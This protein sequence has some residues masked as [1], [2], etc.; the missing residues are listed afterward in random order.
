[1]LKQ[2]LVSFG[3]LQ[4]KIQWY[5]LIV[6]IQVV[7]HCEFVILET[8]SKIYSQKEKLSTQGT[9]YKLYVEKVQLRVRQDLFRLQRHEIAR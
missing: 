5:D 4:I 2:P 8:I 7:I 6:E 9:W 1:M 3:Q